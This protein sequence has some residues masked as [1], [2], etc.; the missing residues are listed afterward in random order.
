MQYGEIIKSAWRITWR[1]KNLW[2]LGLFAG[3]GGTSANFNS[4]YNSSNFSPS[5][6][7]SEP[8]PT[9]AL[10]EFG[11]FV[12]RFWPFIVAGV[13]LLLMIWLVFLILQVA[14]TGGLITQVDAAERGAPK[15][16]ALTGWGDGFHR[17]WP[18]AIL[19]FLVALPTLVVLLLVSL[20][21]FAV[22]AVPLYAG[23]QPSWAGLIGVLAIFV[24]LVIVLIPVNLVLGVLGTIG[25]RGI[26]LA[27]Q[28]PWESLLDAWRMV[29]TRF[30]DV[31]LTWLILLGIAI[32]FGIAM[33]IVIL[34]LVGVIVVVFLGMGLAVPRATPVLIGLG[35]VVGLVLAVIF[36]VISAAYATFHSAAWTLFWRR[37]T[38]R[39]PAAPPYP[40]AQPSGWPAPQA[41][42]GPQPAAPYG[43]PMA[44]M[45]MPQPPRASQVPPD[46]PPPPV[47]PA[48]PVAPEPPVAPQAPEPPDAPSGDTEEEPP[49]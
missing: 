22:V 31:A 1:Y 30:K 46:V 19:G 12:A 2:W 40:A 13:L 16:S 4:N 23:G 17:F 9:D 32:G 44:P 35:V 45:P 8:F 38:G 27:G 11:D 5:G 25:Q 14:A 20:A 47:P 24:L 29:R 7:T 39:Q 34:V 6:G 42:Y 33:A 37:A 36:S 28:G 43:P 10:A 18:L 3:A 41:P 15:V 21:L 48:P 49:R 26:M